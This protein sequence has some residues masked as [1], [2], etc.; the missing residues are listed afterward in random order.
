MADWNSI[1]GAKFHLQHQLRGVFIDAWAQ[2]PWNLQDEDQ[3]IA[4][5]RETGKLLQF[6]QEQDVF[7]FRTIEDVLNE[8]QKL[9]EEVEWLNNVI[10]QNISKFNER[11]E[12]EVPGVGSIIAW[13][14][15]PYGQEGKVDIPESYQRCDGSLITRGKFSGQRTPDLNTGGLFLRGGHITGIP[16][17]QGD[18]LQNHQHPVCRGGAARQQQ[19]QK[20]GQEFLFKQ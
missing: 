7:P 17:I 18:M 5:R 19:N 8:N 2:Q 10:T 15:S 3:Q 12:N 13:I 20:Q 11:L 4:F 14:P 6:M 1:I 9:K 16:S